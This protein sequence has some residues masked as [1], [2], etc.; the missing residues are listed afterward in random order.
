[1]RP[2]ILCCVGATHFQYRFSFRDRLKKGAFFVMTQELKI[3]GTWAS[4]DEAAFTV[5]QMLVMAV[6]GWMGAG[7]LF[8]FLAVAALVVLGIVSAAYGVGSLLLL[9]CVLCQMVSDLFQGTPETLGFFAVVLAVGTALAFFAA[10][11]TRER[12]KAAEQRRIEERRVRREAAEKRRRLTEA[13]VQKQRE[14]CRV[15]HEKRR[16]RQKADERKRFL[17]QQYKQGLLPARRAPRAF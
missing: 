14:E 3:T 2:F 11:D 5:G 7:V 6:L 4:E 1:M 17:K 8:F 12:E 15:R 9:I 13:A 16:E 10:V